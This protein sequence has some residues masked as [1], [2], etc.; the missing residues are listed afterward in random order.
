[1]NSSTTLPK[2]V[3]NALQDLLAL[4]PE[5]RL[6]VSERLLTDAPFEPSAAQQQEWDRR[7]AEFD[8]DP[9]VAVPFDEAMQRLSERLNAKR[10]ASSGR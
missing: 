4:S 6:I 2:R 8:A 10:S 5:Q 1:M 9:S 3:E 7:V